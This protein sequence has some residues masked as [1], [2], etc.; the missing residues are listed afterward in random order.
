MGSYLGDALVREATGRAVQPFSFRDA[1]YI[2]SLGKHSSVVDLFGIPLSGRL[3]WLLWA[4]AYLF[5]MVGIRKQLEVGMDHLTHLLFEHDSSQIMNRREVLT[6][7]EMN[8]SLG[9]R[10]DAGASD[11]AEGGL[12]S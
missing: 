4:A 1:G 7:E 3:A 9:V 8:L 11:R 6:D 2:I 5:K 10:D 12:H